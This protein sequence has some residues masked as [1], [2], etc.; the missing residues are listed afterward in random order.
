MD[1]MTLAK[2]RYSVRAFD[3]RPVESE[4]LKKLVEACRIAPTAKNQQPQKVFFATSDEAIKKLNELSPCIYGAPV[5]IVMGYDKTLTWVHP[6]HPEIHS[7]YV[8]ASICL[9]HMMLEA[10]ELGLGTCW[11]ARFD[12]YA[13]KEALGLDDNIVLTALMPVGYP[14]EK[15]APSDRHESYRPDPEWFSEI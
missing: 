5:V 13:T 8:D 6:D 11:V 14:A 2:Q 12:P 1:F 4:K 9:T 3:P 7:G 15:A 10:Q